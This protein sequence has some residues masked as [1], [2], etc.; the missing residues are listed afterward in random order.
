MVNGGK[1][2]LSVD[3]RVRQALWFGD[4]GISAVVEEVIMEP[5]GARKNRYPGSKMLFH[6]LSDSMS[7]FSI[8]RPDT[9][10]SE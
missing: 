5:N 6:I 1:L 4:L 10:K 7:F 9:G 8:L 2:Q 3:W